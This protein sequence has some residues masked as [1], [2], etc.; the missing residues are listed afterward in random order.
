MLFINGK[1][2]L[3]LMDIFFFAPDNRD[4]CRFSFFTVQIYV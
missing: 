4:P 1:L 2:V 3:Y